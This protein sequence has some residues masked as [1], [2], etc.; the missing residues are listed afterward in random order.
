MDDIA[1]HLSQRYRVICPD[2]IGRG[3]SQWSPD[4]DRRVLPGV[5]RAARRRPARPARHR[6]RALARHLDGRRDR[7][8]RGGR[9]RCAGRIRQPG[10]ERHRP[11]AAAGGAAAH[12]HLCRQPE[13]VRHRERARSVLPHHLQ[14]L[15]LAERCAVAPPDRNLDAPPAR[16]PR[17]AALRPGDGAAVRRT[18]PT[19]TSCGTPGTRSTSR[20]CAC[21]ARAP[22]CCCPTWPSAMRNRGP[23]AVVV[24]MPGCG[25]APALNTPEQFALVERFFA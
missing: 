10:A 9:Q 4:P 21:A 17:D 3:L 2:T 25:H 16:R 23:R 6:P 11:R 19:T 12:P 7:P 18:T 1:A 24:E 13:R 5:L 14:A 22:T 8:A 20:C 15:R